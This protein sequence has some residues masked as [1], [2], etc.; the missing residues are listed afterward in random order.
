MADDRHLDWQGCHNARDLGGLPTA[1]GRAT[2]WGAA[3]RADAPD[4]LSADGWAALEAHGIRTIVDLRND[5]ELRPDLVDRPPELTT[6]HL[7]LDAID[8]REFWDHWELQPRRS[9]T[10]PSSSASP[11]G[12]RTWSPRSQTPSPAGCSFIASA[13]ATAPD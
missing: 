10:R 3:V 4:Q 6:L 8:D 1:D 9:T 5:D 7:P 12:R 11:T 2:R 13:V